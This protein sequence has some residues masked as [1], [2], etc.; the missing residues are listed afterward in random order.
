V[1][2][3]DFPPVFV[4]VPCL[5]DLGSG[6]EERR[7]N[8]PFIVITVR[9]PSK[10]KVQKKHMNARNVNV[11]NLLLNRRE[12]HTGLSYPG[13]I[14]R[15]FKKKRHPLKVKSPFKNLKLSGLFRRQKKLKSIPLEGLL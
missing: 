8:S 7:A 11:R 2:G 10:S 14:K 9:S 3:G 13:S 15:R 1:F 6:L 5:F 12:T 4:V